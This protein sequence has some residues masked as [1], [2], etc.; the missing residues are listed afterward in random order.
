MICSICN[1]FKHSTNLVGGILICDDC[2]Q[3]E[4]SVSNSVLINNISLLLSVM[5]IK[6][7]YEDDKIL[8]GFTTNDLFEQFTKNGLSAGGGDLSEKDMYKILIIRLIKK[9]KEDKK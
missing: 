3:S 5:K 7:T 6:I 9:L 4:F 1:D 8:I 2:H